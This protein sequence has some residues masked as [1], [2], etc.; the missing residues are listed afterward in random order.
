MNEATTHTVGIIGGGNVGSALATGLDRLGHR[1]QVG[2]RSPT[3]ERYAALRTTVEV[4]T[5]EAAARDADVVVLAVPAAALADT[6]DALALS[7][8]QVVIDATN[9]V[10]T[11]V[12]DGHASLGEFVAATVPTGVAVAKAFNTI[13]AEHLA[14]GRTASGS[15]FLPVAGDEAARALAVEL[16][17]GLGFDVADLGGRESIGLVEAHA[18]LWIHLAF[19]GGWGR[20]FAFVVDRSTP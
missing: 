2:V 11:S 4:T 17:E 9:A 20:Q 6:I 18:A 5:I 15:A 13:G 1:V 8:T 10:R 14:D 3:D 12:P 16:A 7:R 19:A